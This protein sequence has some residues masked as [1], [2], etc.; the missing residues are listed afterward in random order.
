VNREVFINSPYIDEILVCDFKKRDRGFF[1][2]LRIGKKLR[3]E[4]FD[5][6]ID[7]QNNKKSH[8]LAF[9]SCAPK[10]FGYDNGKLSFLLNRRIRDNGFLLDPVKHQLKVLGLLG[11]SNIDEKP[12]LWPTTEDMK[13]AEDF[14]ASEWLKINTKLVAFN[15]SSSPKWITK[16]WPIEYFAELSNK[17][18]KELGIRVILIG[19]D[20]GKKDARIDDFLKRIKCKPINA[21]GKTN[22]PRLAALIKKCDLLLSAD[23]APIHVAASVD[24]PFIAL[25][26]P[27]DPKRH[28][29][30]IER[31]EVVK[32]DLKCSPCYKRV[33]DKG[34]IC[35]RSIKPDEVYSKIVKLLGIK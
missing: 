17:L 18:A 6:V 30:P 1:G 8:I 24:T 20:E 15:I 22:I 12:E 33:C 35:M 11:I 2:L 10:R 27:T 25:F 9:L 19:K 32:K 23:S 31:S 14:F 28:L 5:I 26:G 34:Y 21:M 16:L 7:L 29:V 4:D 3:A 13:W